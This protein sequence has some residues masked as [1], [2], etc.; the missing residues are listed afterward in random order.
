M[1]QMT[2]QTAIN[3]DPAAQ[4]QQYLTFLVN[5]DAFAVNVAAVKELIELPAITHVPM[6]PGFILG[7]INLRGVVVPVI[8]LGARLGRKSSTLSKRS[9]LI[10]VNLAA[11]EETHVLAMLVDEVNEII[12]IPATDIHPPP[13]FGANIRTEFIQGMGKTD[14]AFL[15]LLDIHR[16]LSLHELSQLQQLAAPD[17]QPGALHDALPSNPSPQ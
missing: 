6:T 8:D 3:P 13:D 14:E 5:Q 17:R 2:L 1:N 10:L 12:A 9:T 7:V 15:I 11:H 4:E 16:V